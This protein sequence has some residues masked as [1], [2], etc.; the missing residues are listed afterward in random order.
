MKLHFNYSESFAGM[1]AWGKAINRVTKRHN[2]TCE[3]KFYYEFDKYASN[4][5]SAIHGADEKLNRWDIT[6]E[7][8]KLPEVDVFFYSPPCQTFSVA[9]KREGTNVDK[10]NLFYHA[11][12]KIEQS[13]PKYCI[14]ENVKGLPSGDTYRDFVN[15]LWYLESKGY[16]NYWKI[17]NTKDY[18]VPQ[19]RE[20][21]FVVSIRSDLYASGK[22]FEFPTPIKLEKNMMDL[23]DKEVDKKYFLSQ[24][25]ID[26]LVF[27]DN[28][29]KGEFK[30]KEENDK[31]ANCLNTRE[32]TRRTDNFIKKYD[33]R[34]VANVEIEGYTESGKRVY[35]ENGGCPT[36]TTS[37]DI[38]IVSN[39]V[40]GYETAT[41]GD[42]IN[43][44]FQGSNTR[45]GR[46]DKQVS[47]TL[48]TGCTIGVY[49]GFLIRRLTPLETFRL[50]GFDD[51]DYYKAVKAYDEKFSK[52]KSDTQMYIRTGNSITVNVI[53]ELLENLLYDRQQNY[54][55]LSLF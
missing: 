33:L 48:D 55:Q 19:N 52:G 2:D 25:M 6:N 43:F 23:L 44:A 35:H 3:L 45:R 1:G 30:P 14:M 17:L 18:G 26:A 32:G 50:Q 38:K 51:N 42:S 20:R 49:D 27:K 41:P 21:V 54:Q 29:F 22:R 46:V 4:T 13:N 8:N 39:T 37:G 7:A 15:M 24:K 9:G 47:Q 16:F 31:I 12:Q 5:F 40:L 11:V 53:E 34:H 28:D 36:L 10:G